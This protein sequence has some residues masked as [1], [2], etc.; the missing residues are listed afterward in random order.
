MTSTSTSMPRSRTTRLSQSRRWK[1]KISCWSRS[2]TAC[3]GAR[4]PLLTGLQVAQQLVVALRVRRVQR[5]DGLDRA[6]GGLDLAGV[7]LDL[8]ECVVLGDGISLAAG[9]AVGIR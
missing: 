8:A 9:G 4:G 5:D 6:G 7:E 3:P 1:E 2:D